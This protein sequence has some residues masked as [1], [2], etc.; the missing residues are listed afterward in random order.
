MELLI[1]I[2]AGIVIVILVLL[3]SGFY[4]VG[5]Q[6]YAIVERFGRFHRITAPGLNWRIP[7]STRSWRVSR[8]ACGS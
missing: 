2:L 6:N 3:V 4:T 5:Q 7:S 1:G 8:C